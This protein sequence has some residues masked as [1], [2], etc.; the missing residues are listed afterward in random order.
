MPVCQFMVYDNGDYFRFDRDRLREYHH[1]EDKEPF[2]HK[3]NNPGVHRSGLF[4]EL[5]PAEISRQLKT[6]VG[7]KIVSYNFSPTRLYRTVC[8]TPYS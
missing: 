3:G 6:F 4:T 8:A 5:F 2:A 7:K 1:R